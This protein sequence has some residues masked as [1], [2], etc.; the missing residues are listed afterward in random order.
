MN[1]VGKHKFYALQRIRRYLS[2]NAFIDSQF[3]HA[4]LI[5][6]FADKTLI[7]K[8]VKFIIEPCK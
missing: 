1:S 7:T 4:P 2:L 6:M 5:W 3:N 8:S